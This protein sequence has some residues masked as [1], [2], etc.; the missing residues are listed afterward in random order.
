MAVT[1][2]QVK[3]AMQVPLLDLKPQYLSMAAEIHAAI[4]K[5]CA[6]QHFILG[7]AD[8]KSTRLNSSHR[9][10]SYAVFCL[11]NKRR[12]PSLQLDRSQQTHALYLRR[13]ATHD[14]R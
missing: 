10:I 6:S 9:C 8:R 4:E 11:K 12:Q 7:P 5:V 14:E 1:R 3:P 13:D 2:A